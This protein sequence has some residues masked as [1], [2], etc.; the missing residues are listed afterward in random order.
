VVALMGSFTLQAWA[1]IEQVRAA[2]D[3]LPFVVA[4]GNGELSAERF[5]YYLAQ[6]AHYLADYARVLAACAAQATDP[7]EVVLWSTS[8]RQAILVE[9]T[10][11]ASH[12]ADFA[13]I[14]PSPTCTAYTSYL[15]ALAGAGS[16]PALV[17]GVLPCFWIYADIGSRLQ[18]ASAGICS[19]P[20]ADWIA[21]YGDPAFEAATE[22]VRCLTDRLAQDAGP[23]TR[24]AMH[25]AFHTAARYEWMFWDA[26]WRREA[27]PI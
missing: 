16:Y 14:A 12:V 27:W 7:D 1:D 15:L 21:T 23:G 18:A 6:D 24:R 25:R 9:R 3:D 10:L 20:Y 13:A 26:A 22:Q 5:T 2:I 8:S 19:H 11:H 17:A 4:L